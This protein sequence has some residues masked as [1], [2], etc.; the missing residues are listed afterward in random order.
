MCDTRP[1]IFNTSA[2]DDSLRRYVVEILEKQNSLTERAQNQ[3]ESQ[4]T[5]SSP[6]AV[7]HERK[8]DVEASLNATVE[9]PHH[10]PDAESLHATLPQS[11][12]NHVEDDTSRS[13][14]LVVDRTP[15]R[16]RP[17]TSTGRSPRLVVPLAP[18]CSF[19]A[20]YSA[21]P[22]V[23]IV[24]RASALSARTRP[25]SRTSVLMDSSRPR[26]SMSPVELDIAVVPDIDSSSNAVDV[27]ARCSETLGW[28]FLMVV[29]GYNKVQSDPIPSRLPSAVR[30]RSTTTAPNKPGDAAMSRSRN[31]AVASASAARPDFLVVSH[32]A[33]KA[34]MK[35]G[36]GDSRG[37]RVQDSR[38]HTGVSGEGERRQQTLLQQVI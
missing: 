2:P 33:L 36:V 13:F 12:G 30:P 1:V 10:V 21:V 17:N 7:S 32:L 29:K 11:Q 5:H 19:P 3:P 4:T 25:S 23:R 14:Q 26:E 31:R 18:H 27:D 24:G 8:D 38:H 28:P 9:R 35:N 20:S 22:D 6:V 16:T 34:E 37:D 15:T